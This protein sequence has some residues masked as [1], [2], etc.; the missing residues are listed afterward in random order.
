MFLCCNGSMLCGDQDG[1]CP[2]ILCSSGKLI[3]LWNENLYV[4]TSVVS[5]SACRSFVCFGFYAFWTV[6]DC[7]SLKSWPPV[8]GGV[9]SGWTASKPRRICYLRPGNLGHYVDLIQLLTCC[10]ISAAGTRDSECGIDYQPSVDETSLVGFYVCAG[11]GDFS[12]YLSIA[13]LQTILLV[14]MKFTM[15]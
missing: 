6:F 11:G 4:F 10:I 3:H 13:G 9:L 2:D 5:K 8:I 14:L 12:N 7:L 15:A 1:H